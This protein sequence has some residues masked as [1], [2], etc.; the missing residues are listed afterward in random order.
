MFTPGATTSGLRISRV[1]RLGPREE[2]AA[3]TGD[4]RTPTL[5]PEKAMVALGRGVVLRYC[6]MAFP[7]ACPTATAGR[8]WLS[9]TSSSP[10]P[11]CFTTC[12]FCTLGVMPRSQRTIFPTASL[13]SSVPS[14]Q[15]DAGSGELALPPK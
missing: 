8:R 10:P 14:R 15:S 1:S 11:A 12:P 13:V 2:N 7:A 3:T 9:A 5:V 6:L 4:G